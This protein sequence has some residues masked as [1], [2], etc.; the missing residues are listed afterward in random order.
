QFSA[1][2]LCSPDNKTSL[3]SLGNFPLLVC[4]LSPEYNKKSYVSEKNVVYVLEIIAESLRSNIEM[5]KFLIDR[6]GIDCFKYLFIDPI[7][8]KY[9]TLRTL[10]I[11]K[12]ILVIFQNLGH[13]SFSG[14]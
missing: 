6:A 8:K 5:Q 2:L 14:N 10:G 12:R 11:I 4:Y 1:K 3:N 13:V 7:P 9:R